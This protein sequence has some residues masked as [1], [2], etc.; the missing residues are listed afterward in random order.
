M[1]EERVGRLDSAT[2]AALRELHIL[3]D[4][5]DWG[6]LVQIFTKP[7]QSR[8]TLFLEIVQRDGARGFGG[9]NI[10]AL[11]QAIERKQARRGTL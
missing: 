6:S 10:K 9:G 1:V 2:L 11:F 4:R 5:D 3:I 8:P 7:I